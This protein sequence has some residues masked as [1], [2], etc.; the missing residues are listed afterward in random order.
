MLRAFVLFLH[1]TG[2]LNIEKDFT[3]LIILSNYG[4]PKSRYYHN[5]LFRKIIGHT[6]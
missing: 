1:S 3:W 4:F 5:I 2:Y 6:V